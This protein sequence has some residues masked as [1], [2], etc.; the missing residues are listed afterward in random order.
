MRIIRVDLSQIKKKKKTGSDISIVHLPKPHRLSPSP[1]HSHNP[2]LNPLNQQPLD[3]VLN[4]P[5]LIL[6]ARGLVARNTNRGD[7]A[8]ITARASEG[9]LGGHEDV[10]DFLIFAE[11]PQVQQ[12][13]QRLGVGGHYDELAD[14]AVERLGRFVDAFLQLA[15]LGGSLDDTDD[16]LGQRGVRAW[17]GCAHVLVTR[18]RKTEREEGNTFGVGSR[19]CGGW[20]ESVVVTGFLAESS[21]FG[22]ACRGVMVTSGR[23]K[24]FTSCLG[25]QKKFLPRPRYCRV[26]N[27]SCPA[28]NKAARLEEKK[29]ITS[30]KTSC[31][32]I[33]IAFSI[34]CV[35]SLFEQRFF[36]CSSC[37]LYEDTSDF[38]RIQIPS[39]LTA[40]PPPPPPPH[41]PDFRCDCTSDR[42][43]WVNIYLYRAVLGPL[44][45]A[46]LT[47]IFE[48]L[49]GRLSMS[50][51]H[52]RPKL[53]LNPETV[54]LR[55]VGSGLWPV[56][57]RDG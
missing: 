7:G 30:S 32:V 14:P 49:T 38:L 57:W 3:L 1:S 35:V 20:C 11:Q 5:D 45:R 15:V 55:A 24:K 4:S 27:S 51:S 34:A 22:R 25:M 21:P 13:L 46:F 23:G 33:V 18:L 52:L 28:L 12:H 44:R 19:H 48:F 43:R 37:P 17:D 8:A 9:D 41:H 10:G 47:W 26:R 50:V 2:N 54:R 39:R 16:S 29:Y 31:I 56:T 6:Q 36:F 53:A 42:K 40:P